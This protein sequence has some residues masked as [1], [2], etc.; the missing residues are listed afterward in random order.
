MVGE[1]RKRDTS[2]M[3]GMR[4]R[5]HVRAMHVHIEVAFGAAVAESVPD[6]A[7]RVAEELRGRIGRMRHQRERVVG[8]GRVGEGPACTKTVFVQ[9]VVALPAGVHVARPR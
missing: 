6:E 1:I 5:R 4:G 8:M 2:G 9:E 7:A 3:R